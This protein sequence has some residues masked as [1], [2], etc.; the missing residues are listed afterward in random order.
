[1]T[2]DY[3]SD[4]ELVERKMEQEYRTEGCQNAMGGSLFMFLWVPAIR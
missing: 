3:T 4:S 2:P 1:M